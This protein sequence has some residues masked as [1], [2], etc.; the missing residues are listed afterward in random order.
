MQWKPSDQEKKIGLFFLGK[1]QLKK[2]ASA[3]RPRMVELID[4]SPLLE[5]QVDELEIDD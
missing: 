2:D 5:N 3:D 4:M 1:I